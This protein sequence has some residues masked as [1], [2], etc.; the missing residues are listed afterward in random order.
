[1]VRATDEILRLV[2]ETQ[3]EAAL[4][5]RGAALAHDLER[6]AAGGGAGHAHGRDA[7]ARAGSGETAPLLF[8]SLGNQFFSTDMMRADRRRCP[9][10]IFGNTVNVQTPQSEELA[11]GAALVLVAIILVLNWRAGHRGARPPSEGR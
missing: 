3:K 8:T 5:A 9:Q 7:G 1:M 10:L 11:W 6:G 2:P 4:R